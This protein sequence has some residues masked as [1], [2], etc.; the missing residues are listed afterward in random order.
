MRSTVFVIALAAFVV[1]QVGCSSAPS[2]MP[3]GLGPASDILQSLS[4]AIPGLSFDQAAI[5]AGSLL[6]LAEA[7]MPDGLF[8]QVADGLPGAS[9]LLDHARDAGLP[10]TD[11]L[12]SLS[13]LSGLMNDAGITAAQQSDLPGAF[14]AL[15]TEHTSQD[16]GSAFMDAIR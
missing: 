15:V 3:G 10:G 11:Q 7:K 16:V 2:N 14:G 13:S 1:L 5:G 9:T 4:G 6:G 8:D 12:T